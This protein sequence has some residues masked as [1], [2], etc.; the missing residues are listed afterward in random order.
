MGIVSRLLAQGLAVLKVEP[1]IVDS[2]TLYDGAKVTNQI[3][4][5]SWSCPDCRAPGRCEKHI[6][7]YVEALV[8]DLRNC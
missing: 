5:E 6:Q 2:T 4:E 7:A 8:I 1:W 3:V